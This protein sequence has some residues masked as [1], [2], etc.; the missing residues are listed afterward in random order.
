MFFANKIKHLDLSFMDTR[1]AT[2]GYPLGANGTNGGGMH[3]MMYGSWNNL[4]KITFG[5]YFSFDGDGSCVEGVEI[6]HDGYPNETEILD[7][8]FTIPKSKTGYWYSLDGTQYVTDIPDDTGAVYFRNLEDA[9]K[10]AESKKYVSL[11]GLRTY[12]S[13]QTAKINEKLATKADID[14]NHNEDYEIKGAAE[15]ALN[16]AKIYADEAASIIKN[17]LLNGAG[18]AY[19]TLKELGDLINENV[20][21]LD[22]LETIA[23]SK[24]DKEYVDNLNAD[25]LTQIETVETNT[26]EKVESA[27]NEANAYTD[28]KI[29]KIEISIE[30]L[31]GQLN[32]L[33][34]VTNEEIDALF[35]E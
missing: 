28:S 22:A 19:D 16:S 32:A 31:N 1:K 26:T 23:L 30:N 27:K 35:I 5:P 12:H 21:A 9:L 15:E 25:I 7:C 14:H 13:L 20:T 18:E 34:E 29:A 2:P 17:D 10:E 24:A 6:H 11:G 3:K 4:E 33:I 8:R